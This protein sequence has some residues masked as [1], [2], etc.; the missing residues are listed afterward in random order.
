MCE[1]LD[2]T[3]RDS[4][5]YSVMRKAP[6]VEGMAALRE[7][8]PE[9]KADGMNFVLFSTRGVHGT[10]NTIEDAERHLNGENP[11]GFSEVTFLVVHPRLVAI[12]FGVCNPRNHADIDYLK[13]L[14]ANSHRAVACIGITM[15]APLPSTA[16]VPAGTDE[17]GIDEERAR[18]LAMANECAAKEVAA[19][20][21][22]GQQNDAFERHKSE[23][24]LTRYLAMAEM[25][26]TVFGYQGGGLVPKDQNPTGKNK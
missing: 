10:Q 21:H 2:D 8:F 17:T 14:R 4:A 22:A 19:A 24:H 15:D 26:D 1:N 5:R 16:A 13:R 11:E 9:A 18:L 25:I 6:G 7:M 3:M 12:R 20:H 23:R